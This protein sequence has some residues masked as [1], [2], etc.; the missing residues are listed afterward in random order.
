MCAVCLH[1]HAMVV[2]ACVCSVCAYARHGSVCCVSVHV[3]V[4]WV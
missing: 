3:V 1:A 2:C 4:A